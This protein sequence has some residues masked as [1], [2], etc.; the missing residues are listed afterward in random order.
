MCSQA[1]PVL[2]IGNV[3]SADL[4]SKRIAWACR[5]LLYSQKELESRVLRNACLCERDVICTNVPKLKCRLA[6]WSGQQRTHGLAGIRSENCIK[7]SLC[8]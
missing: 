3:T 1:A 4:W 8:A 5:A 6:K 2:S 7:G